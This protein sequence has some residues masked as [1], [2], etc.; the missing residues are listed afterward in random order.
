MYDNT[1][2][3]HIIM[4]LYKILHKHNIYILH[5]PQPILVNR[6]VSLHDIVSILY[7]IRYFENWYHK[8]YDIDQLIV[9]FMKL[10]HTRETPIKIIIDPY[11]KD[12]Q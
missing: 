7:T 10:S 11:Y 3:I 5:I 1:F 8:C 2:Q 6:C 9:G 12:Q 4:R